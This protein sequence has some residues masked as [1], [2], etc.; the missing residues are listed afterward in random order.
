MD[1]NAQLERTL[2]MVDFWSKS[3]FSGH[4][5]EVILV[6]DEIKLICMENYIFIDGIC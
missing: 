1:F 3:G 4:V 2:R 6:T 5:D